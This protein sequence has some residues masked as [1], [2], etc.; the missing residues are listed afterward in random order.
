MGVATPKQLE[1]T[2]QAPPLRVDHLLALHH[3]MDTDGDD[4]NKA[5]WAWF[6]FVFMDVQD[7]R[8]PSTHSLWSGTW[9]QLDKFV[10][11]SV[12]QQCIKLAEL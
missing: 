9:T 11:L 10:T 5:L 12:Q 6:Y 7:G 2:K 1:I 3:V 4:W 8:T